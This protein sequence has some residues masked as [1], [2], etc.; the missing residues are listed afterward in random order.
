MAAIVKIPPLLVKKEVYSSFSVGDIQIRYLIDEEKRVGLSIVPAK[1]ADKVVID[2]ARRIDSI[3]QVKLAGDAHS[4]GYSNG[5]TLRNS[6]TVRHNLK[7]KEQRSEQD[8]SQLRIITTLCDERGME[9][10]HVLCGDE[11]N[12]LTCEVTVKNGTGNPVLLELLESFNISDL[13]PFEATD[14]QGKL[15]IYRMRAQWQGE[16]MLEKTTPE[17][18]MMIPSPKRFPAL[19]QRFGQIGT[20]PVK[21]FAPFVAIRDDERNVIWGGMLSI[22][23]SWQME[24]YRRDNGLVIGGGIADA[25]YGAWAKELQPGESFTA[26]KAFMSVCEGDVDDLS[27][28]FMQYYDSELTDLPECEESLPIQYNEYRASLANPT[29]ETVM[30]QAKV[31]TGR[32]ID[33]FVI[34]A[35]WFKGNEGKWYEYFGDWDINE[36]RFPEGLHTV[37]KQLNDLGF[38]AGVWFEPEACGEKSKAYFDQEH[39]LRRYGAV[40]TSGRRRFWNFSDPWVKAYL[41]NR[42]IDMLKENGFGYVKLDCNETIG[43]GCDGSESFGEGVRKYS[44]EVEEFYKEISRE[45]PGIVI[46]NC[47]AGSARTINSFTKISS[48]TSFSDSFEQPN[49]PIIAAN[50]QRLMPARQNLV[51]C[52]IEK[53]YTEKHARY[54]MCS[55]TLGRMCLSGN[56]AV[57]TEEQNA[58]L[59]EFIAY[60]KKC[61]PIIKKGHSKIYLHMGDNIVNPEGWQAVVRRGD[62]G[63]VLVTVHTFLDPHPDTLEIPLPASGYAVKDSFV[64]E[65][66]AVEICGDKLII[67]GMQEHE[68]A[69]FLLHKEA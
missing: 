40:L 21:E 22:G 68:G 9:V 12:V 11:R 13:T 17:Q 31:L 58:L 41:K 2:D 38:R 53:D 36:A 26:P 18:M 54:F 66:L 67:K 35:G 8:G 43:R 34:D 4:T 69:T 1:L 10:T 19:S 63:E 46:E 37:V 30:R 48:V 39:L 23:S 33:Y 44:L 57:L 25:D 62:N 28:R 42:V 20:K 24:I 65:D 59:D 55:S 64:R 32:G 47:S 56:I 51:W 15:S 3:A 49:N 6:A 61:A 29:S 16:G 50:M 5:V 27:D 52:I 45:I 60:Y 14:G 7:L